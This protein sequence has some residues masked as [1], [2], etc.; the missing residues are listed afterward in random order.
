MKPKLF[1]AAICIVALFSVDLAYGY[2]PISPYAY[3]AGNP[4]KYVDPD[5]K[6]WVDSQGRVMWANGKWT[7]YATSDAMRVGVVMRA[8]ETGRNSFNNIANGSAQIQLEINPNVKISSDKKSFVRG[9]L[10]PGKVAI[11]SDG[12]VELLTGKIVIFE[13]SIKAEV[14]G[15]LKTN[16]E[17]N[18][19]IQ[20]LPKDIAV[21]GAVASVVVHEEEHGTSDNITKQYENQYQ[22]ANH[23][24]EK[25]PIRKQNQYLKE[26]NEKLNQP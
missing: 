24:L 26:L 8:T 13:G 11:S 4:I 12:K 6:T 18:S 2:H 25:D 7:Q 16:T 5:G 20:A 15:D 14:A 10:E 17:T 21:D 1:T 22:R 23:D 19:L 9:H 3:C